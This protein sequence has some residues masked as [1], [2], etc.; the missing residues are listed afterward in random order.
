MLPSPPIKLLPA[1]WPK[2]VFEFPVMSLPARKPTAVLLLPPSPDSIAPA[3][4]AVFSV[5]STLALS[6]KPPTAVLKVAVP[7]PLES[8]FWATKVP[9]DSFLNVETLNLSDS[10][11]TAVLLTGDELVKI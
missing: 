3:P 9:T 4:T 10:S 5:P 1:E 2:Q 8:L 11:P 6:A 7:R